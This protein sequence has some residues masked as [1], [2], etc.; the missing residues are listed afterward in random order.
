MDH[1]NESE[2]QPAS[3]PQWLVTVL[4]II[5]IASVPFVLV[6]GSVR[7]A[8]S[9]AF[10]RWEY[11]R[12][13]FPADDYGF[14]TQ[15]RLKYGPYGLRYIVSNEDISYLGDLEIDGE[16]AFNGSELQHMEDVQV[17][18][19]SAMQV[20]L[21]AGALLGFAAVLLLRKSDTRPKFFKG[22]QRGA[23]LTLGMIVLVVAVIFLNWDLFFTNF[24]NAFFEEGTWQFF[25]SDTLIRLYPEQFWF[26]VSLFIGV[27]TMLGAA[28]CLISPYLWHLIEGRRE[29]AEPV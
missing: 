17:V 28:L 1:L 27:L 8:M 4:Q 29:P 19:R 7:L 21:L 16:P 15:D 22:L 10:M 12:S 6:L 11:Q 25:R 20:L 18:T 14:T 26:D 24:H 3:Y 5:V 9:E 13:G 23:V 2:Y